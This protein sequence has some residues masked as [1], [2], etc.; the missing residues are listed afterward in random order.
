MLRRFIRLGHFQEFE[1]QL[2]AR[3]KG[4][5]RVL[6]GFSDDAIYL[7]PGFFEGDVRSAKLYDA[8]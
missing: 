1:F 2:I 7:S 3:F 6:E 5:S 8:W 4:L